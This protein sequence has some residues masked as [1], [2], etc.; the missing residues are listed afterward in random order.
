MRQDHNKMEVSQSS[1]MTFKSYHHKAK[2]LVRDY[3]LAESY[4]PYTSVLGGIFMSKMVHDITELISSSYFTGY[5]SLTK[6]QR[7][8]WKNRGMSSVHAIFIS[9]MSV[10][11]VFFS[12]LF[13]DNRLDGLII[14]RRSNLSTFSLGVSAGYFITDLTMMIWAYP[15]LGGK[16][17]V[18]HHSLA[19]I[20]VA[21]SMFSGEGHL[22]TCMVLISEATTPVVNLRWF[23]DTAGLKRSKAYLINGALLFLGWLVARILLF[24][25]LFHHVHRHIEQVKQMD[26]Y[27]YFLVFV[28][29]SSLAI[30]NTVWFVKI[31]RGMKKTWANSRR[32]T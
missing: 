15:I 29:P 2:L 25:Y 8:E 28:V 16:E 1:V 3:L 17:Y 9:V 10:Y 12:D 22:Y 21:Y 30:M 23:L 14:W 13:S 32:K 5:S 19:V 24:F 20:S 11:L 18:F 7:I 4:I 6:T 31:L 26:I 27:G